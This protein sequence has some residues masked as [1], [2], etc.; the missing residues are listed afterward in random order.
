MAEAASKDENNVTPALVERLREADTAEVTV[1]NPSVVLATISSTGE[2]ARG[3]WS[4][5]ALSRMLDIG[6][7]KLEPAPTAKEPKRQRVVVQAW[8]R[9]AY[10]G[11]RHGRRA[12]T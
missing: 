12:V 11:V 2:G 1:S 7:V 5:L 10:L 9:G 4:Y 3:R 6:M 8:A